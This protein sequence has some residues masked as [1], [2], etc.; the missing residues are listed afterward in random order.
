MF[1][2]AAEEVLYLGDLTIVTLYR[3]QMRS[4]RRAALLTDRF[5][6]GRPRY[7]ADTRSVF[8]IFPAEFL[9]APSLFLT[10]NPYA[11]N[12]KYQ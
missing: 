6:H 10:D 5:Y 7:S 8:D 3:L 1:P 9:L 4:P 12:L 2:G 11:T